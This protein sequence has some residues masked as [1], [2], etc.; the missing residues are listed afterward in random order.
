MRFVCLIFLAFLFSA[1]NDR[2]SAEG[3]NTPVVYKSV[4]GL[5]LHDRG[6]TSDRHESG[7]N[8]N[9]ELQFNPP[10]W[11]LW[12]A[13]GSPLAMIGATPNFTG[14]TSVFYA[15]L[16][17]ELSLSHRI[18]DALTFSFT[19]DLFVAAG[20]SAAIHNGPL[21]KNKTGCEERSD[22]GF[23]YRALPRLH[24]EIGK[25]FSGRH[26]LS[27]F[28]DHMSHKGVL[29]GENEGIDH[30]GVRYHLFLSHSPL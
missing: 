30:V 18:T 29:P 20:L 4:F 15:G 17:Y 7:I 14:D 19:R 3:Q 1:S 2:L 8:P 12:R 5:F 27:L 6:P 11:R 28:Y 16:T 22:C 25:K 21:H 9:W 13:I 26:G 10:Q 24:L 23:G